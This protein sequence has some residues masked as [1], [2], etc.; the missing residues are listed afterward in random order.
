[1][2]HSGMDES[3]DEQA[4]LRVSV[5]IPAHNAAAT[6]GEQLEALA[7][8]TFDEP[9]EVIVV[10]NR[11]DDRT[12]SVAESFRQRFDA[13]TVL[14]A[15][16]KASSTYARNCGSDIAKGELFLYCDADD[17]VQSTWIREM[18]AALETADSVGGRLVPLEPYREWFWK[19]RAVQQAE[20]P[21]ISGALPYISSASLGCRRAVYTT[22]GGWD[23]RF[24]AG[25]DDIA[26]SIA[27]LREGF[28]LSFAPA[29]ICSYR[30]PWK[31]RDVAAQM[32]RYGHGYAALNRYYRPH[33]CEGA[34][35]SSAHYLAKGVRGASKVRTLD[36]LR[37]YL[38]NMVRQTEYLRSDLKWRRSG[39]APPPDLSTRDFLWTAIGKRIPTLR[40]RPGYRNARARSSWYQPVVDFSFPIG[41]PY[42]GGLGAAAP[43]NVSWVYAYPNPLLEP[44]SLQ[45]AAFFLAPGSAVLDVGAN[46]GL[47]S[48]LAARILGG[49]GAITAIEPSPIVAGSLRENLRRHGRDGAKIRVIQ[50]AAGRHR[51]RIDLDVS[52]MS[53]VSGI[54]RSPY[55][56]GPSRNE[57]VDVVAVDE[58]NLE[59]LDFIKIDV[60]G[61]EPEVLDGLEDTLARS[62]NAVLLIELNPAC[63]EAAGHC[64]DD[65]IQHPALAG[66][67][68]WV[69]DDAEDARG[70][71]AIL[72]LDEVL[73]TIEILAPGA[74]WFRNLLAIPHDHA[75]DFSSRFAEFV[76]ENS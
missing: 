28:R 62:P 20:L 69:I 6:L 74:H 22:T 72:R 67:C 76:E 23:E 18:V 61:Y 58:L 63:L 3:T 39:D 26:F 45:V 70:N 54:A 68:L 35:I 50:A 44:V 47:F 53:L 33:T 57:S 15:N 13:L 48:I 10:A 32:R 29:A 73:P 71:R 17:V 24:G 27:A 8:Q 14:E 2:R 66:R 37:I 9:Y 41:V 5:V 16:D 56:D 34:V 12:A 60:E 7:H 75:T 11:C 36:D 30:L 25:S 55:V 52:P 59:P 65:L 31:L 42:L 64:V 38:T 19:F 49:S 43:R 40:G 4:H 46:I 1:M 51:D 21:R